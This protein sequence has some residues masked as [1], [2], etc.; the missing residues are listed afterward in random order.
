MFTSPVPRLRRL[1]AVASVVVLSG[2]LSPAT[3]QVLRQSDLTLDD[4]DPDFEITLEHLS[5]D[6]RW[7]GL[8]PR[9]VTWSPDGQW[10]YFQWRE[11]PEP[12][13]VP[14]TDPWYAVSRNGRSVREI[15]TALAGLIPTDIVWSA[16]R[17]R[18]AWTRDGAL[19]VWDEDEDTRVVYRS[20][21]D[22]RNLSVSA[23]G[24]RIYFSH[25]RSGGPGE[26]EPLGFARDAG[27]LWRIDVGDGVVRQIA[28]PHRVDQDDTTE[29]G[30]WLARQQEELIDYIRRRKENRE[31][32]E[33]VQRGMNP[34]PVQEIPA[35]DGG[36]ITDVRPSPDER[37]L[38]F[39]WVKAP[40]GDHRTQYLEAVSESGYAE[41]RSARP[42][43][44]EPL[45][46]FRFGIV[47]VDPSVPA[48]SVEVTWVEAPTD[49]A[50]VMHGPDWSPTGRNAVIQVL[51]MDHKDRWI[52]LLDVETAALTVVDHQ[53]ED[54]WI[55][56]PLVEGRWSAGWLQWLPDGSA[57]AFG[58]TASGYAHVYLGTPGGAVTALT[59]G[60]W[61]VR[62]A[63]LSPDGAW[64]YLTTSREHPGEEHLYR[65]PAR[66]GEMERLTWGEGIHRATV[67]P[68]GDRLATLYETSRLMP[69]LYVMDA[70]PGA[71]P[72]R[73]T[74]SGTDDF[75]R[76]KL[77]DSE[78]I[79]FQD[80]AGG[81][82]WA[83]IWEPPANRNG[84]AIVQVHGC[85]ECA[86]GVTKGWRRVSAKL[87]AKYMYDRGFVS[88]NLDYRGSS[89]YG[90]AN[91][92]YAYRQMG[93]T[94]IDSGLA[95]LD[96]L[97]RDYG[98]DRER[99]GVYGGSYGGFFTIMA[100]FRHP[101]RWR[102]GVAL[103][104]VTD[105]AHYN[106]GYTSRILNGS[107]AEDPEAYRVSSPIYYVDN[108]Q[109]G[110]QIQHGL[111]DNNVQIQDSFRLAQIMMEKDKDFDLV[112]YP[113]EPHGWRQD[114]SRR[115][116]F[117]RMTRWFE[118]QLLG[119]GTRATS[120]GSQGR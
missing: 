9:N 24:S 59:Q 57:F 100:V 115:D 61:E 70:E 53:H 25:A 37:Y 114:S 22:L 18:A 84:A 98:V 2:G 33:E 83:E 91:R 107:P 119:D 97:E 65:V 81:E 19:L 13:Q 78:I 105:W 68:D 6:S 95:L 102:A 76:M 93:V 77:L 110:L 1:V 106:Q 64:W 15:N 108:Y 104:P 89:G 87:Y 27:D 88:A 52:A 23:D 40:K 62:D 55:G 96:I 12:G 31:L 56:G 90:H 4:V 16:D 86:Q 7:M 8:S 38:T 10:L 79:S 26:S 73:V 34:S 118:Q 46:E 111:V 50:V 5:M 109:R 120:D 21:D 69:D 116:S 103:Y 112:V 49:K 94:D 67:S 101:E 92:T 39:R 51:S 36:M 113:V 30:K 85:G 42:K 29:A 75:Y 32:T 48:D 14:A 72:T 58:S 44:G 66:G 60:D 74:K 43:V 11:R 17:S 28:A 35:V 3:A 47:E 41:A 99:I 71:R 63:R 54:A 82:T 117:R 80:Y 20:E 45:P